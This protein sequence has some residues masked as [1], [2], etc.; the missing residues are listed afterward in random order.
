MDKVDKK[1]YLKMYP[2]YLKWL[3][4]KIDDKNVEGTWI[5]PRTFFDS[6][7]Y[8]YI[9]IGNQVTISFEVSILVHD[10]SIVHAARGLGKKTRSIIYKKV[11]IGDNVFIGAKTTILPGSVIGNNCIVGGT[12]VHGNLEEN[13]IYAG[14][15]C[16]K[17]G[18]I[19]EFT[20][21]YKDLIYE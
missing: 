8:D 11:K 9:E 7:K 1:R 4:I 14:N 20:E 16:R 2:K 3:G 19:A 21:K 6:S 13:S 5:S 12:V 15:P 17:I 10:F 18:N